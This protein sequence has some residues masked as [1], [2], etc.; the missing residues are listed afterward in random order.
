MRNLFAVVLFLVAFAFAAETVPA[1]NAPAGD[2]PVVPEVSV[3]Q[4]PVDVM[5]EE[6]ALRDSVMQVR[7]SLCAVE[8]DSM[9]KALVVEDAKCGNWEQSYQTMKENNE[10]CAK[11]L[12]V[13]IDVN[14]KNKAKADEER[15]KA[16]TMGTSSFLGGL[17]VGLL[18]MWLIMK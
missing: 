18:V 5:Q 8:K 13:A 12:G 14:E 2:A 17:A 9:R 11:A 1:G 15:K 3:E 7:D 10:V 6:L 4:V 16:A